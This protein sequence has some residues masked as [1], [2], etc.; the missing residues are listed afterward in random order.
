MFDTFF[1]V[2]T[3]KRSDHQDWSN[4]GND[5]RH[6]KQTMFTLSVEAKAELEVIAERRGVSKSEAVEQL[7]HEESSR[8]S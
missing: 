8:C 1:A 7:I 5:V 6:R 3:K 4:A 2:A